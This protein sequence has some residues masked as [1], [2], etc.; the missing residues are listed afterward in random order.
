MKKT[1]VAADFVSSITRVTL[2][3]VILENEDTKMETEYL[4]CDAGILLLKDLSL[5][6]PYQIINLLCGCFNGNDCELEEVLKEENVFDFSQTLEGISMNV[7]GVQ[8]TVTRYDCDA[9]EVYDRW[10]SLKELKDTWY[11]RI[12]FDLATSWLG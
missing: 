6:D 4:G 2:G 8:I 12:H 9:D 11:D 1:Q 5:N 7:C 3:N 10:C